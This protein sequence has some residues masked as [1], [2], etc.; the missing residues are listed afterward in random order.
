MELAQ[1]HLENALEQERKKYCR[2]IQYLE[3]NLNIAREEEVAE[4]L[5]CIA[6]T[7]SELN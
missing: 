2:E 5:K 4:Y 6:A 3:E 1:T 7:K